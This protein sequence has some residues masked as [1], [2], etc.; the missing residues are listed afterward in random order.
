MVHMRVCVY[1]YVCICKYTHLLSGAPCPWCMLLGRRQKMVYFVLLT[2]YHYKGVMGWPQAGDSAHQAVLR[3]RAAPFA[4]ITVIQCSE[5]AIPVVLQEAPWWHRGVGI[6]VL[7]WRHQCSG[8][9]G[10]TEG[11]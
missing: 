6:R 7:V 5:A 4:Q 8:K 9:A 1:M 11:I 2:T 3:H 10:G